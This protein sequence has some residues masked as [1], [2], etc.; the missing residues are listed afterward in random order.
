MGDRA[1]TVEFFFAA[2][3]P[4]CSAVREALRASVQAIA[5]VEWR[6]I[7]IGANPDRAVDAGVVSTPAVAIDGTLVFRTAPSAAELTAALRARAREG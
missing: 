3:C 1:L 2:G 4:R 7:D 6:D 5:N